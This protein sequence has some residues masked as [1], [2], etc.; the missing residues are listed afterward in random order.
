M[1]TCPCSYQQSDLLW[2]GYKL[3]SWRVEIYKLS[4]KSQIF[5][6]F[7]V[8][9]CILAWRIPWTEEPGGLW[10]IGLQR[11]RHDWSDLTHSKGECKQ[12]FKNH[13]KTKTSYQHLEVR[14]LHLRIHISYKTSLWQPR[15]CISTWKH[16]LEPHWRGAGSDGP[17]SACNAGGL[18][19]IPGLGRS[20]GGRQENPLEY[21]CLE[22]SMDRGAWWTT[23]HGMAK[24]QTQLS[25]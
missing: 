1:P 24:S 10:S 7:Q 12:L 6:V 14:R 13:T 19:S 2:G 11:V 8:T 25:D 4:V 5:G 20:P 3:L 22:N 18:G 16:T 23:V 15:A 21:C 9:Y 17:A